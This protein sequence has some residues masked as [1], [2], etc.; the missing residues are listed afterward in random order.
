MCKD[1]YLDRF[2]EAVGELEDDLLRVINN[3]RKRHEPDRTFP[4]ECAVEALDSLRRDCEC[5]LGDLLDE[6]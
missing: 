5:E 6:T 3:F 4:L 2:A 1:N